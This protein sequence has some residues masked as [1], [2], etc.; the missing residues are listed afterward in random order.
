[1]SAG[2]LLVLALGAVGVAACFRTP[3]LGPTEEPPYPVEYVVACAPYYDAR[4]VA[5]WS[6]IDDVRACVWPG[7]P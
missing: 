5:G 1:M 7:V 6:C 2:R 4:G 3:T